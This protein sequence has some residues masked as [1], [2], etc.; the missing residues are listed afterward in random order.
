MALNQVILQ[1][2]IPN[3][4]N[5]PF[6]VTYGDGENNRS[7]ARFS[8]GVRRNWKAEGEQYY[9]EDIFTITAFGKKAEA[10]GN[11]IKRGQEFIV[12]CHLQNNS[13]ENKEGKMVYTNDLLLDD[14]YFV[15]GS[16]ATEG[17]TTSNFES[18]GDE[19]STSADDDD[20]LDI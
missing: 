7:R 20:V 10:I 5:F 11:Y 3:H 12:V 1:G 9:P 18:F 4:E 17:E 19:K 2:R 13:Y 6:D 15:S 14:F 16:K 8:F